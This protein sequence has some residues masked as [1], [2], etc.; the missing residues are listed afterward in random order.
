MAE[1]DEDPLTPPDPEQGPSKLDKVLMQYVKEKDEQDCSW[2]EGLDMKSQGKEDSAS[3]E[4][5]AA[6]TVQDVRRKRSKRKKRKASTSIDKSKGLDLFAD[7]FANDAKS[8]VRTFLTRYVAR[9]L[10]REDYWCEC[11]EVEA[12]KFIAKLHAPC[13]R[14]RVTYDGN[15]CDS[16]KEAEK[17]AAETFRNDTEAQESAAAL[18]ASLSSIRYATKADKAKMSILRT[19]GRFLR[20]ES[21]HLYNLQRDEGCKMQVWDGA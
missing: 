3:E 9:Q 12:G 5:H 11:Q 4:G 8:A 15:I 18:P 20:D 13:Y 6:G 10:T 1:E 21:W 17:S 7:S 16:Q 14:E 2:E 19:H